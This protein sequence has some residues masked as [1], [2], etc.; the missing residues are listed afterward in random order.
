MSQSG[1]KP[2]RSKGKS[3]ANSFVWTDDEQL[4]SNI[5]SPRP[6]KVSIGNHAR[7][8]T[9]IFSETK[10]CVCP[11]FF[12]SFTRDIGWIQ[13][14]DVIVFE[15][16]PFSPST[17][18]HENSVFKNFHSKGR[19]RKVAFSTFRSPLS[20]DTFGRKANPQRKSENGYVWTGPK[21]S[22]NF[23]AFSKLTEKWNEEKVACD[24][25]VGLQ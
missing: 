25:E 10:A 19:F 2:G 6:R 11:P 16:V 8:S 21:P 18:K 5:R 9:L 1:Q 20:P 7:Q 15:K 14:C 24:H 12:R 13:Y 23:Q 3:K 17:R 22:S 4:Q